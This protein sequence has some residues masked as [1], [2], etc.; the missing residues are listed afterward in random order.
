MAPTPKTL[1][2]QLSKR[3]PHKVLRGDLSLAG[4]PGVVYT[5][6]EGFSLPAVAFAHGWMTGVDRYA[7]TLT[8]LA[9]WG[10]VVAAPATQRTP[11][12]SHLGLAADLRTAVDICAG[13]RLGPGKIS[14]DATRVAYAGHGMGAGAAVIAAA[15][16]GPAAAVAALFPAPTSP[17][18]EESAAALAGPGLII[19]GDEDIDSLNCNARSIA[20]AWGGQAILR[21]VDGGSASGL[22]EGRRMLGAL[23]LGGSERRTQKATR[24]L[25]TGYLLYHLLGETQYEQFALPGAHLPGSLVVELEADQTS[26]LTG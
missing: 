24:A 6:A 12:P 20:E 1:A 3:G 2:S 15:Q 25:L 22:P 10:L 9:S 26:Q 21:T 4:Q 17:S 11:V 19:A 23:G 18:A 13:V 16:H 14:V 5:P 8:H 7:Q